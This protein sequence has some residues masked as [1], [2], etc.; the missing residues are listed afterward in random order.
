MKAKN[1]A[2][3]GSLLESA[4]APK[5]H[6]PVEK[7]CD[8]LFGEISRI[9]NDYQARTIDEFVLALINYNIPYD[10]VASAVSKLHI[11]GVLSKSSITVQGKSVDTF[12]LKP[13]TGTTRITVRPRKQREMDPIMKAPELGTVNKEEGMDVCIWKVMQDRKTRTPD[14][15]AAILA[16]Y[17]FERKPVKERV[18]SLMKQKTWF[19]RKERGGRDVA[20]VLKKTCQMPVVANK[21]E[22]P[23]L[24]A[25]QTA[26]LREENDAREEVGLPAITPEEKA[27][28][29][30]SVFKE[31]AG[32]TELPKIEP[33]DTLDVAIW[34]V[35]SD[36]KPYSSG[37]L[38]LLLAD[39][40]FT[41]TEIYNMVGRK[42]LAGWFDVTK[43]NASSRGQYYTLRQS[44]PMPFQQSATRPHVSIPEQTNL[45][46]EPMHHSNVE[47]APVGLFKHPLLE[48][49]IKLKGMEFT[50][51]ELHEIVEA[52]R[53]HAFEMRDVGQSS[54]LVKRNTSVYVQDVE[55]TLDEVHQVIA[56]MEKHK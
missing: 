51:P 15:I 30:Q 23:A 10:T 28:D 18:V 19:D 17:G 20:Y 36:R 22:A 55:F 42:N 7:E 44:V 49:K 8:D 11:E 9:A 45:G 39:L 25:Q 16:T 37:D 26:N 35:M 53:I 31:E 14:E 56:L 5:S 32:I 29:L 54:A 27:Q 3:L 48:I 24:T 2:D 1:F 12:R 13:V 43:K 47:K 33:S 34:K 50:I 38:I 52:F 4:A 41:K 6:T 46:S 40:P 21:Q